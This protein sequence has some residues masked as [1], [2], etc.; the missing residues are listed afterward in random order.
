MTRAI[1]TDIEGTT[2]SIAFVK[3]VLFPYAAKQLPEWLREQRNDPA[4]R[5][6]IEAV[7]KEIGQPDDNVDA[8]IAQLL[9]WIEQDVKA[10]PLKDLQGLLWEAGYERGDYQAHIY[11]D[12][13]QK[14]HDWHAAGIPLY[15]YSS[16]SI[17][18]QQLFFQYSRY[19]DLRPL[20]TDYF[21]TTTGPKNEAESYRQI[22]SAIGLEPQD[23]LFLSDALPEI[24]AALAAGMEAV[25]LT[26]KEDSALQAENVECN[27]A[28]DFHG[29]TVSF[30][31]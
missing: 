10:T 4:V 22:A 18:A 23:V 14:L 5:R 27:A 29:I 31:K 21:D 13:L 12:A 3:D 28:D 17:R 16:G 15:V 19:G 25:L 26:R 20:F 6:Q 9:T 1:L 30:Q 8:V 7:A 11:D 24:D 2:S